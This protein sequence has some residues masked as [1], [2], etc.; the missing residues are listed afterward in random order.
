MALALYR[1]ETHVEMHYQKKRLRLYSQTDGYLLPGL[2]KRKKI[3]LKLQSRK[4]RTIKKVIKD[5]R[6]H[7]DSSMGPPSSHYKKIIVIDFY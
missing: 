1:K 7:G 3:E 4:K 5:C 2:I 6:A